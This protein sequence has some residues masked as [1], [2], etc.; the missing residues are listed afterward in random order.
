MKSPA[1]QKRP[2]QLVLDLDTTATHY[3][4]LHA[5]P[6]GTVIVWETGGKNHWH[7]IKPDTAQEDLRRFL[8]GLM[9]H[10]DTYFS[11]NEFHGWRLTRL[12]K[13]LRAVFVDLDIGREC[14]R[15]DLTAALDHLTGRNMPRPNLV[16]FSGRG[17]HFYWITSPTP[18]AALPVWQACEKALIEALADFQADKKARD[19]TRV[20][21][22]AGTV[23]SKNRE[24]VRGVVLDGQP[25]AFHHL[26]D[27]VLG[28]RVRKNVRRTAEVRSFD[29][30]QIR[31]GLHPKATIFRR[32]HLVLAD[33][34]RIGQHWKAIPEHHR[35][36]YLFLYSVALSWFASPESI[37]QE[38][39]DVFR[40]RCDS[41]G[42]HESEA[43]QAASQSIARA[44]RSAGGGKAFWAGEE[45]DPRY[46]FKR[47]T[48]WERLEYL[49]KP[50]QNRLR[51]II[52]DA[53]AAT[54]E[55]ERQ[56]G[57]DR[58]AEGR[59]K[60]HYT[61][62]GVRKKNLEKLDLASGLRAQGASLRHI[63][64][65]LEVSQETIRKWLKRDV[66]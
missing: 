59:Y 10:D 25:F 55:R 14:G 3:E 49:A 24:E 30:A 39:V 57:R 23:N 43:I 6:H 31:H 40:R 34:E 26:C 5:N 9:G 22:L 8:I 35:N 41:P 20:L 2:D 21:R 51:A 56:A 42:F 58:V 47:Q 66:N 50:M 29:A 45:R 54:R 13:S 4:L 17:M 64:E 46:Y 27:E 19:C 63:A 36:E 52:P 62:Q 44:K 12:L 65:A 48:L 7:K 1:F 28:Y 18:A 16:V 11:I 61:G 32:W 33:L 37:E 38:V 15:A 60:T 53:L